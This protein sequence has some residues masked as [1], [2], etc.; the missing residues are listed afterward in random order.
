MYV[1]FALATPVQ[2]Y[3]GSEFYKGFW[4]TLKHFHASMDTLI[5]IG[6]SAAYF[7]SVLI[8]FYPSFINSKAVYYDTGAVI[9]TLVLLGRYLEAKAKGSASEAIKKLMGLQA[10]TALVIRNNQEIEIPIEQVLVNDIIIVKPGSKIPVDGIVIEGSSSVD[11]SMVTGESIPV[12][13][14][15]MIML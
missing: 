6:T 12:E 15:K 5:A 11:E 10:K 4:N 3:I 14:K 7:Y 2:F 8:T 1:L 9:I 13:K